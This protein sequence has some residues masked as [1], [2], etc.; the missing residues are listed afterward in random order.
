MYTAM[1]SAKSSIA[2]DGAM[3]MLSTTSSLLE[4]IV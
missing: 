1:D 3:H 2:K 4:Q